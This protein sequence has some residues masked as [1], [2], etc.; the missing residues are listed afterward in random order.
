V[1]PQRHS[2]NLR[3]T[4]RLPRQLRQQPLIAIE[5]GQRFPNRLFPRVS[6]GYELRI[7]ILQMLRQL[8]DNLLHPSRLDPQ[9]PHPPLHRLPPVRLRL[10]ILHS[11]IFD[12][13]I[14]G[15]KPREEKDYSPKRSLVTL[16]ERG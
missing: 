14:S 7:A 13:D 5:L 4:P 3:L 15:V 2:R 10:H 12:R 6:A 9:P 11:D 16:G 8:L 1:P